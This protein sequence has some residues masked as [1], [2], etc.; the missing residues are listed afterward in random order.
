M[1]NLRQQTVDVYNDTAAHMAQKFR[2]IGA[3]KDDVQ[4]GLELAGDPADA[5]VLEIGC[6]DGRD[7]K[8]I[9]QQVK[10]F[11]GF[12]ISESFIRI[13]REYVPGADFVVADAVTFGYPNNLD[14]VFAFASLL[15]L[16]KEELRTV[17]GKVAVALKLGGIFYISLKWAP[18]Y[19]SQVK[20][21]EFGERLFYFYTPEFVAELAT[22][23]Y[24][25]AW[26]DRQSRSE[27]NH[28]E[29]FTIA[30]RKA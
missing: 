22:E 4:R 1:P 9:Y 27:A 10:W 21:D 19:T 3:R 2:N 23:S 29:W 17:L 14:V 5:R 25:V 8:E 11:M 20:K 7:A 12:D 13:A 15:H 30:L 26:S 28:T 6:G 24:E 18:E 16:S